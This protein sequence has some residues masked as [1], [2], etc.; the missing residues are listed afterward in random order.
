VLGR[1]VSRVANLAAFG[2]VLR[3]GVLLGCAACAA[4]KEPDQDDGSG[5]SIAAAQTSTG[6][7]GASATTSGSGSGTG[8]A[9]GWLGL[10]WSDQPCSEPTQYV[11]VVSAGDYIYRFWPPTGQFTK[12][13]QLV[14]DGMPIDPFSMAIDRHAVAWIE[15]Y[16]AKLF[17]VDLSNGACAATS[18]APIAGDNR[19]PHFGMAFA[20]TPGAPDQDTLFVRGGFLSAD[21][22]P[23]PPDERWLGRLDT[24]SMTISP[25]GSAPGGD[26]ELTASAGRVYSLREPIDG[27]WAVADEIDGTTGATLA[28]TPL[29]GVEITF[30]YAFAA[31]G[32][33]FWIFTDT[34]T[35]SGTTV[36]RYRPATGEI[37]YAPGAP[38]PARIVGAGV[39]SCAPTTPPS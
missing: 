21:P 6:G 20:A 14:C 7:Q 2:L 32:G 12:V 4:G 23:N 31:W 18:F 9:G 28:S 8:G 3:G 38:F 16:E 36:T 10:P 37:S 13:G 24:S 1:V 33:D 34:S 29:P 22:Q 17:K 27:T 35:I 39:S 25:I 19:F 30:D 26:G 15:T 11:Y 5:G